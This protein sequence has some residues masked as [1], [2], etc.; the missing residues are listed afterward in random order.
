[1]NLQTSTLVAE[2]LQHLKKMG[3]M[4][5]HI[6]SV[7]LESQLDVIYYSLLFQGR[8]VVKSL[9]RSIGLCRFLLQSVF[10]SVFPVDK[11]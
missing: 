6:G 10:K 3:N 11:M 1:M 9:K 5:G 2:V 8:E 4:P 7:S